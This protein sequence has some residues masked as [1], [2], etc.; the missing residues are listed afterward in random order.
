MS[1]T[2]FGIFRSTFLYGIEIWINQKNLYL[3]GIIN[4]RI[5]IKRSCYFVLFCFRHYI[6]CMWHAYGC[7]YMMNKKNHI[8][9]H[10]HIRAHKMGRK[11][12]PIGLV[13]S[14]I[15]SHYRCACSSLYSSETPKPNKT[16]QKVE[17]NKR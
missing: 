7:C 14:G 8:D 5:E 1:F 16:K 13:I 3:I 11:V 15:G 2:Y 6:V 12:C 9:I 10:I 4:I 17:I